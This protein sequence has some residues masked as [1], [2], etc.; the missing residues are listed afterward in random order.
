ML[1]TAIGMIAFS[2]AC[3]A[4][5]ADIRPAFSPAARSLARCVQENGKL[6]VVM[7]IDESGSLAS[8]DPYDQ[9]IDGIRAA[10]IGLANLAETP[11][12]DGKAQVSV[13]MAGFFGQVRP[14]P[15]EGVPGDA[16]RSVSRTSIDGLLREAGRYAELN[17]GRATDYAT[18]L[19]A[20]RQ[21][22]AD[23]SAE[24]TAAGGA[25]CK[26]LIWFT[27]GRYALPRR[28]GRSGV[29]LPLTV[30]YAPGIRLDRPGAGPQA[31]AAG[32]RFMCRPNGLMD[33]LQREGVVRFTVALST[34]LSAGDADFL[35]AATTGHANS[36]ECGAH[37]SPLTGEYL[38]ARDGDRLLFTFADVFS[39]ETP[40]V[41]TP[42]CRDLKCVR[43]ETSFT[44]VPGLSRLLIRASAGSGGSRAADG[45]SPD[46]RLVAPGGDSVTLRPGGPTVLSLA[47]AE[48]TQ[49]WV[50]DRAVEVEGGFDAGDDRWLGDW[51]YAFIDPTS[52]GGDRG[53]SSVQ[54]FS[55]LEPAVVGRPSLI[56][57]V[58]S[59]VALALVG[60]GDSGGRVSTGPLVSAARLGA[61]LDEPVENRSRPVRVRGPDGDGAFS[62]TVTV[63][64]SSTA[65]FAYLGVTAN[66]STPSGTPIAPQYRAFDLPVR[67]PPNQ[68]YPSISPTS[69]DLPS[70]RGEGLVDGALTV[71]GSAAAA[72]CAWVG[73]PQVTAPSAAGRVEPVIAPLATD[74]E[75]CVPIG[76]GE[77]RE[78]TIEV[79][80]QNEASGTASIELPIHL[81]SDLVDGERVISVPVAFT[82]KRAPGVET[83]LLFALL[84]A[85][86]ALLPLLLL[87]LLNLAGARFTPP[88]KLRA[89]T[90]PVEMPRHGRLRS[91]D[92]ADASAIGRGESLERHGTSPV[93]GLTVAGVEFRTVA[94]G[95]WTDRTFELFRGPYGVATAAGSRL[96]AGSVRQR[97]RSWR[98]GSAQ[99][100]P[101][102]LAGTW[103]LRVG[104]LRP[105]VP[106]APSSVPSHSS[107]APQVG[108]GDFFAT[109][110]VGAAAG[111]SGDG[112]GTMGN[113][114]VLE[115]T[116][117][118]LSS[119][120]EAKQNETLFREAEQVL[121][122]RQDLW[123][124]ADRRG[125]GGA[126]A[127]DPDQ[128]GTEPSDPADEERESTGEVPWQ[129]S[130]PAQSEGRRSKDE[131]F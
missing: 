92:L 68:G 116:L 9:R 3:P 87:H 57:G 45:D 30:P 44:T 56:R 32:K 82:M 128:A 21:M 129:G 58:P 94:S 37:L 75:H 97:L 112:D 28:V 80:P 114:A 55:D 131:F 49:R 51:S 67:L 71:T 78:L 77:K 95:S 43:G 91:A 66:F 20:A 48:I 69:L 29:G 1:T 70:L 98:G 13:L 106:P 52:G 42:I 24:E 47:G 107:E 90:L 6:S 104:R 23:R 33:G 31:I 125:G 115:G 62:A 105:A 113:E 74:A 124:A 110:A 122:E 102:A 25:A 120:A 126:E 59:R 2:V 16:W 19:T 18:A 96:L 88:N 73:E 76:K 81:R 84:I 121:A 4:A 86:G 40:I 108:D 117:I 119:D 35:D 7:L 41:V 34:K 65:G 83:W 53:L 54:L 17:R 15:E 60:G 93:R 64:S 111:A 12:G 123:D 38:T 79:E 85:I 109:P 127:A 50:S 36:V 14:D 39:T 22:L 5:D 99:E 61:T 100:V 118:L 101:L 72:G 11:V 27:D 46:L 63:P 8:T 130:T 26:A 10:L 89:L 103:V